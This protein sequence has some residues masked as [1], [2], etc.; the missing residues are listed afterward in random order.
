VP[1]F[2]ELVWGE[3]IN[4]CFI[5]PP[6]HWRKETVGGR[7]GADTPKA[8]RPRQRRGIEGADGIRSG[9]EVSPSPVAVG[10]G[11]GAE[12]FFSYFV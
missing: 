4:Q 3:P 1:F 8:S 2:K 10:S 6:D 11:E 12:I 7:P 9:E 5:Q